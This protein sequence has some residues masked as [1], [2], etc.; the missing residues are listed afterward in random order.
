MMPPIKLVR[1]MLYCWSDQPLVFINAM[2]L[3]GTC[4]VCLVVGYA[5]ERCLINDDERKRLKKVLQTC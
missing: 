1:G 3:N 5:I 4:V 2:R